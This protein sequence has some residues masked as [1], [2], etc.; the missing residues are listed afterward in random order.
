LCNIPAGQQLTISYVELAATRQE[1]KRQLQQQYFFD[2]DAAAAAAAA[3]PEAAA[4]ATAAP[5]AAAV[6]GPTLALPRI[7]EETEAA[8]AAAVVGT[9]DREQQSAAVEVQLCAGQQQLQLQPAEQPLRLEL[10]HQLPQAVLSSQQQLAWH[11]KSSTASPAASDSSSSSSTVPASLLSYPSSSSPPWPEDKPDRQLCQ[12][13]LQ[14]QTS[15][16]AGSSS[17]SSSSKGQQQLVKLPGGMCVFACQD[18]CKADGAAAAAAAAAGLFKDLEGL[19]LSTGSDAAE[20][21]SADSPVHQQ[22]Q[23]QQGQQQQGQQLEVVQWG[24]W[25]KAAAATAAEAGASAANGSAYSSS[26]TLPDALAVSA[27]HLLL[28]VWALHQ[29]AEQLAAHGH[30]AAAVQL[31]QQALAAAD[32]AADISSC[33]PPN[34]DANTASMSSSSSSR[35]VLGP[36]HILRARVNAGLLKAAVDEGSSWKVTLA[37]AQALTPVYELVY[38]KVSWQYFQFQV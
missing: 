25:A 11:A 4:A 27:V 24:D 26:S 7:A 2:I 35:V 21:S 10:Q 1:R 36:K 17:S 33:I 6:P 18:G 23:A 32:G 19:E 29:Q 13:L 15:G 8:A 9:A 34:A 28:H 20:E 3:A 37:A 31:Y 16:A 12:V 30:A 22:G 5:E 14:I 38:P